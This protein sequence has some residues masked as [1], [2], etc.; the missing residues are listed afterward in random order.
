MDNFPTICKK[1]HFGENVDDSIPEAS[2]EKKDELPMVGSARKIIQLKNNL[3][4]VYVE[5]HK[6]SQHMRQLLI[7]QLPRIRKGDLVWVNENFSGQETPLVIWYQCT[8]ESVK[9]LWIK[10][11]LKL[12][13]CCIS[14]N[15]TRSFQK[16]FPL[17]DLCTYPLAHCPVWPLELMG[18][19]QDTR[20]V[21]E[22]L[23]S[24][25]VHFVF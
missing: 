18:N 21:I 2:R 22:A 10:D 7:C 19:A 1:S 8:I 20:T 23:S 14:T 13:C 16:R 12:E 15:K 24:D 3:E 5:L 11:G 25:S 4:V 9:R 17:D 6:Q